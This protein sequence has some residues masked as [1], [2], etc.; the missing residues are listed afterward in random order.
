MFKKNHDAAVISPAYS[1][2]IQT[3]D[4]SINGKGY[5]LSLRIRISIILFLFSMEVSFAVMSVIL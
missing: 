4:L 5:K 3:I 2:R 1:R